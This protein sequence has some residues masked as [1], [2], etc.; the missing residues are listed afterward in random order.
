MASSPGDASAGTP[1][2]RR[3]VIVTPRATASRYRGAAAMFSAQTRTQ[4]PSDTLEQLERAE[5][6]SDRERPQIEAR[7]E[8]G[9]LMTTM[10]GMTGSPKKL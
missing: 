1:S 8:L 3:H 5:R 10:T 2:P 9:T 6:H 4:P 7:L